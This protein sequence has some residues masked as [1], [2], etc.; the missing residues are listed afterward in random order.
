MQRRQKEEED[1]KQRL[2]TEEEVSTLREGLRKKWEMY[3]QRYAKMTH[4][5]AFDNLVLLRNKEGLEKE[6]GIIEGDLKKLDS[7]NVIIDYTK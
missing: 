1:K 5:K 7:K 6:L 3:N 2:L 4:K